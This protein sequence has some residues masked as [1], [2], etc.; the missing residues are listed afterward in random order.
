MPPDTGHSS[1]GKDVKCV[2]LLVLGG[3][4]QPGGGALGL[5][6]PL[7]FGSVQCLGVD[8]HGGHP[9]N[10][11]TLADK[12]KLTP[13]TEY[14]LANQRQ[15]QQLKVLLKYLKD[16]SYSTRRG[17]RILARDSDPNFSCE[18]F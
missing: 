18:K 17:S 9:P 14:Q 2:P 12:R 10:W 5:P 1:D 3:P 11:L 6:H 7:Q 15:G 16:V 4:Y 8:I 13:H